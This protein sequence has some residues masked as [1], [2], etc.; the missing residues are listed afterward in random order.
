MSIERSDTQSM[1]TVRFHEYGE[2]ATVLRLEQAPIPTPLPGTISVRVH[3]CGLNPA[4]WALCQGL[5]PKDLPRGIGLDV[6]GTVTALGDGV[7]DVAV[8][9]RVFGPS[10]YINFPTAGASEHAV[11][12]HWARVPEGLGMTEAA[13][14]P[15]VVE[16]AHRYITVLGVKSGETVVIHGAGTMVGFAA[17]Q[18][19]VM[20]GC[21]VIAT[22]GETFA[23]RLTR[24]GVLVTGYGEGMVD[25][26][27]ALSGDAPDHVLDS[28]PTNLRLGAA[29]GSALPDLVEIARGDAKRVL[30]IT[31]W[32]NAARLGVR[33]GFE[34]MVPGGEL[35]L[36]WHV[37]AEFAQ[38]AAEGRFEIPIARTFP[39]ESWREAL[40]ISLNGRARGKLVLLPGQ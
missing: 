21:R 20:M 4:D 29:A 8:G 30:T 1:K 36:H 16:T 25:R 18:M 13:G 17:A 6:S 3:G 31:D 39:L 32:E 10:D 5:F 37:L 27:R 38:H 34:D 9:D 12:S 11:L 14:L 2:P 23:H 19:A 24:R 22:A 15:V 28:A 40:D 26:V 35:R 33:T 7:D